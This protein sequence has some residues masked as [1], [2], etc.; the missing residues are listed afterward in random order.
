MPLTPRTTLCPRNS[1]RHHARWLSCSEAGSCGTRR[2]GNTVAFGAFKMAKEYAQI[3]GQGAQ[4]AL[5]SAG[6]KVGEY[7]PP[8]MASYLCKQQYLSL[9]SYLLTLNLSSASEPAQT[10]PSQETSQNYHPSTSGGVGTLPGPPGE[11]GIVVPPD[12]RTGGKSVNQAVCESIASANVTKTSPI[13]TTTNNNPCIV[14]LQ[15]HLNDT[16]LTFRE[17]FRMTRA[18]R[19]TL[20]AD[21]TME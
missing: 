8:S 20:P 9:I 14:V 19:R 21:Y 1:R 13:L 3:A 11:I 16:L 12:E 15:T 7:L 2:T 10:L 17:L 18:L 4:T 5:Q 6:D